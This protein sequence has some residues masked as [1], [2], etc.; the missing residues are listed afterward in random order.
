MVILNNENSKKLSNLLMQSDDSKKLTVMHAIA[1]YISEITTDPVTH[2]EFV[3]SVLEL[4][5]L[6]RSTILKL[7]NTY[8][9]SKKMSFINR[10]AISNDYINGVFGGNQISKADIEAIDNN[11]NLFKTTI[12]MLVKVY[13]DNITMVNKT[14]KD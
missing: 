2:R 4:T 10:V 13:G 12:N 8:V 9:N 5:I 14:L 6:N 11:Y 7:I 3:S 1:Y